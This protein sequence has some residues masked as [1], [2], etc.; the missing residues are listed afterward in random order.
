[1]AT[2][3]TKEF[4][5]LHTSGIGYLNRVRWVQPGKKSSGRRA[6]PFLACSVSALRGSSDD[7]NYTYFDL[8]VSGEDAIEI[9]SK[10]IDDV[11]DQRKV[12]LS[13]KV[14]DIYPHLYERDARDQNRRPTGQKEMAVLIK[15]RLLL[16]NSVSVDGERV[17]AREQVPV[18]AEHPAADDAC[19]L[20]GAAYGS[21]EAPVREEGEQPGE[22]RSD[23]PAAL[24][25]MQRVASTPAPAPVNRELRQPLVAPQQA[26]RSSGGQPSFQR[27]A[28][29]V[30]DEVAA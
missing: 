6:D 9:V 30:R 17:Y 16:I 19:D 13:F 24:P 21:D 29:S 8:R 18:D 14:G 3:Q 10:L 2:S 11:N 22:D 12:I 7:V 15:G 26:I 27:S 20:R 5:N 25:P 28:S 23:A 4:F 1:M